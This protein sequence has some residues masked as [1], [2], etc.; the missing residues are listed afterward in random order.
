MIFQVA[1]EEEDDDEKINYITNDHFRR[2]IE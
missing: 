2:K 1:M